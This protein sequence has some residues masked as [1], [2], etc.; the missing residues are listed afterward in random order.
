MPRV[1]E[2]YA[3]IE[4][5]DKALLKEM[6]Q[7]IVGPEQEGDDLNVIRHLEK[8]AVAKERQAVRRRP[9]QGPMKAIARCWKSLHEMTA[10][11]DV[12]KSLEQ[13]ADRF[14]KYAK[15]QTPR[16]N[17]YPI[18]RSRTSPFR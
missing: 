18:N 13:A 1:M 14:D 3:P 8:A 11:F 7:Y 12:V 15:K 5:N 2:L 10:K 17:C 6:S 4:S 9:R 16:C